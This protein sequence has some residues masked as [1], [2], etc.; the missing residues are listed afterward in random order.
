MKPKST[1]RAPVQRAPL[2]RTQCEEHYRSLA[3][4]LPNGAVALFDQDLRY[5][6]AEGPGLAAIG[7]SKEAVEGRTI[8]EIF[9][10]ETCAII[11]SSYRAALAGQAAT[12]E[13]P[14]ADRFLLMQ[15]GPVKSES[16]KIHTGMV[17]A[18]DITELRRQSRLME[19]S[20]FVAQVGGWEL[21]ALA[22]KLYWTEQTYEL[23]G[24]SPGEYRPTLATALAFYAPES[25]PLIK[26][27][28]E[29]GLRSAE[30]WDLEVELVTAQKNRLWVRVVGR[31]QQEGGRVVR[32]FG[33]FQNI[34]ARKRAEAAHA[35]L[36]GQLR[37]SQKMDAIGHLAGG[38]AHDFNNLLTVIRGQ[39]ELALA[40]EPLTPEGREWLNQVVDAA[41][42]ASNL[43]RQL[44]TFSRKQ[45]M[46]PAP[47]DLNVAVGNL[48]KLLGRT[49]GEHIE[50]HVQCAASLPP[51]HVDQHMMEQ[52]LMNLAINACDAMPRG[53]AL[54]ISTATLTVSPDAARQQ[55]GRPGTYV[56]LSVAD[57]GTG[58]APEILP[59]IFE[60]F[61]T[62]KEVGKGTGLGLATV[63]GIVQQHA[64][65]IDVQSE[66]GRGTTFHLHLPIARASLGVGAAE[67]DQS[68]TAR[69]GNERILI[70]EDER[71]LRSLMRLILS[72]LGYQV[73]EASSGVAALKQWEEHAG[74]FDLVISDVVMPYAVSG[75]D[76]AEQLRARSPQLKILLISGYNPHQ[77]EQESKAA[78]GVQFLAKPFTPQV[79]SHVVRK[80]LDAE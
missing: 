68:A 22:D 29:R 6:F 43:T 44:L 7:L 50:L 3:Q 57:T 45:P 76:L 46:Q 36:E 10:P 12:V 61:F 69:G 21:D 2:Q 38:V 26:A 24:M 51:V 9:P 56:R 60:P 39:S 74:A 65:W 52:A 41:E 23:H 42:R 70:V 49:I 27:A 48:T 79:L 13:A 67:L 32:L 77:V 31:V 71:A 11:E 35:V 55:G 16:G 54:T 78:P 80:C 63:H 75:W 28:F 19:Q 5:I 53:G 58:I 72:R 37:Q 64:G 30:P 15:T 34:S 33:S 8:W 47:L 1:A 18:Q 66:L 25:E 62:T 40:Y 20:E 17:L 73:T 59:R 4:N 14:V